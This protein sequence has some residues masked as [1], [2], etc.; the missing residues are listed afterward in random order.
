[1]FVIQ[2]RE[3]LVWLGKCQYIPLWLGAHM[4]LHPLSPHP[5][6][7]LDSSPASVTW[8]HRTVT[9]VLGMELKGWQKMAHHCTRW[10]SVSSCVRSTVW[11]FVLWSARFKPMV[12]CTGGNQW[13]PVH[14]PL[15][16]YRVKCSEEG[17]L[18]VIDLRGQQAHF[19]GLSIC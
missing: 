17:L 5:V 1:M 10:S 8:T 19:Q 3:A 16:T 18:L 15:W 9:E 13:F 11:A 12:G 14:F 6:A 7:F 4:P 2:E